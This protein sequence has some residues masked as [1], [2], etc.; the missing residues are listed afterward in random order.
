MLRASGST[1]IFENGNDVNTAVK[2]VHR[3]SNLRHV[4]T[5]TRALLRR[6]HKVEHVSGTGSS[7]LLEGALSDGPPKY[8]AP[9]QAG[10]WSLIA[11]KPAVQRPP[12]SAEV[13]Q[14]QPIL[15]QVLSPCA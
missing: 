12:Q 13:P 6:A 2:C 7:L 10:K 14:P 5:Q 3:E 11:N 15:I 9:Q 8:D 1:A 4:P